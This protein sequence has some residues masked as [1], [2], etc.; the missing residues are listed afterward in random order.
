MAAHSTEHAHENPGH[1]VPNRI[2]IPTG[3]ALLFLTLVTVLVAKVHLGEANIYV[4]M[5]IAVLKAS[6]VALFF[7]HLRW[8]RPFN[9]IVFV[10][11][12]FF[13]ALFIAFVMADTAEYQEDLL[14]GDAPAVIE[15]MAASGSE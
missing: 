6:L 15:A 11:S 12:L 2:L 3:I 14:P 13:V 5:G 4:A 10:G 8:D 9:Q 1:I 7:M